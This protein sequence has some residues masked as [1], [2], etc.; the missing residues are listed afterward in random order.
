MTE[1][2]TSRPASV[3]GPTGAV[4]RLEDLPPPDT[5]RWGRGVGGAGG[6]R[7]GGARVAGFAGGGRP[8]ETFPTA[9]RRCPGGAVNLSLTEST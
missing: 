4:L 8:A 1:Q 3:V 6:G 2:A 9:G 5:R 7:A